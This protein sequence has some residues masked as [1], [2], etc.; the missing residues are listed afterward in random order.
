MK[1]MTRI[2][3]VTI[4]LVIAAI[5]W[6]IGVR[7]WMTSLPESD[8]VIRADLLLIIPVLAIFITISIIQMTYKRR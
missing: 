6:E 8:P 2:Q 3:R 7:I 1:K 5:L 4:I